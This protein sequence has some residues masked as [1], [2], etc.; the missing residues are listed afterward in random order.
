MLYCIQIYKMKKSQFV[1][2][3][4]GIFVVLMILSLQGKAQ[5]QLPPFFQVNQLAG[6]QNVIT[7][8]VPFLLIT[9]DARS[10]GMGEA[11]AAS[12]PDAFSNHWNAAKLPFAEKKSAIGLSYSPWLRKLR[13]D[14]HFAYL[15]G[16]HQIDKKSALGASIRYFSWGT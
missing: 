3:T 4:Y 11:G 7:T 13:P 15:S 1:N 16:Y 12:D 10:A 14:I 8:A 6:Q 2:K 5:F 9:P